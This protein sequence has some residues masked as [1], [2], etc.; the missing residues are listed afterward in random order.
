[1]DGA[2][3]AFDID[4]A[5]AVDDY[6]A[7]KFPNVGEN[8][9][10]KRSG[11]LLAIERRGP[12]A[13]R[14]T[15]FLN[16]SNMVAGNSYRFEFN[17]GF[18]APTF[19]AFLQD[20]YVPGSNYPLS[21]T[22]ASSFDFAVTAD[23]A[24]RAANRFR[25]VFSSAGPL[26]VSFKTVKAYE[27]DHN[28][29]VEWT[30]ANETDMKEYEVEKST[31]GSRFTKVTTTAALNRTSNAYNW[32][33]V[34]AVTGY[35]YY[36][37]RSISQTGE[38]KYSDIVKVLI[39]K[40]STDIT[41]YPNPVQNG[42]IKL[43]MNNMPAGVYRIRVV[44]MLG[45]VL[46]TTQLKHAAGN[47]TETVPLGSQVGKGAYNLEIIKPDNSRMSIKVQY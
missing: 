11:S 47:S 15:L 13:S 21:I 18:T 14:D 7:S 27:Q 24:T 33:D 3:A 35:N 5:T 2:F 39:G 12:V 30:T 38:I 10:F 44:N 1:V 22:S 20:S 8:L 4:Y 32:T 37:I 46:Q 19:T 40:G 45:Q 28:I 31:D 36:R 6:D 34:N 41:V 16:M 9:S 17:P 42:T 43:Q 23:P 29:K 26:A 25:I